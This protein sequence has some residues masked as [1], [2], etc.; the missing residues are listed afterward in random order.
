[1][2]VSHGEPIHDRKAYE[3]ALESPPWSG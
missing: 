1:V 2:I 3:K